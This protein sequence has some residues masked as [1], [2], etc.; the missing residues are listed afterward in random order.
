[1]LIGERERDRE[2]E[3]ALKSNL[4]YLNWSNF[5]KYISPYLQI[6]LNIYPYLPCLLWG[7]S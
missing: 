3:R 1:M 4:A 5:V 7:Y 2:R 6:L